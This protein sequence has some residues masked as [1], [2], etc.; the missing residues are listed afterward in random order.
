MR[1]TIPKPLLDGLLSLALAACGETATQPVETG[2]GP[3]PL[4]PPPKALLP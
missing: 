4:L 1:S 3:H 2:F